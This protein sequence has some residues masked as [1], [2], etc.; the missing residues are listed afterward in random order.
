MSLLSAV[1]ESYLGDVPM[2]CYLETHHNMKAVH[3]T[4]ANNMVIMLETTKC[5]VIIN[6]DDHSVLYCASL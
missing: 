4:C 5:E 3:A 2:S 6:A 1:T